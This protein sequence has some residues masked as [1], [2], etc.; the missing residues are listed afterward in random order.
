MLSSAGARRLRAPF[1]LEHYRLILKALLDRG[2]VE[3]ITYRDLAWQEVDDY[4][5]GYP[6]EWSRWQ[7]RLIEGA[8]SRRTVYVLLQHDIDSGPLQTLE[9]LT[10]EAEYGICSTT[11]LFH[12]WRGDSES[13][14][15]TPYPADFESFERLQ[16]H[17]SE[18]GYHCNAFHNAGYRELGI[19]DHF[20]SDILA[21]RRRFAIEF[22]SPHGG[23]TVDGV[24]N[25]S[26]NYVRAKALGVRQVHNGCSPRFRSSYSDGGLLARLRRNAPNLDPIAWCRSLE[27]GKRYRMLIHPQYFSDENFEPLSDADCEWYQ[28]LISTSA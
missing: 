17:G 25:A 11:M 21:L 12:R 3:F 26:F 28:R 9:M 18:F 19:H 6:A 1:R 24:G 5:E 7:A 23:K 10:L 20:E 13:G 27:P 16:R 22:F 2:D 14:D 4:R 8:L 15:L